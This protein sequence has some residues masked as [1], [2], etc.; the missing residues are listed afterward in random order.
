M[1]YGYIRVPL[2][3]S[4]NSFDEQKNALM[5][6]GAKKIFKEYN[7][8]FSHRPIFENLLQS[9]YSG[10]EIIVTSLSNFARSYEEL[11]SQILFLSDKNITINILDIGRLDNSL[12]GKCM[13]SMVLDFVNVCEEMAKT[14][15]IEGKSE[16]KKKSGYRE[17]RPEKNSKEQYQK[18]VE[19]LNTKSYS[20]VE[21]LTGI[22]R[23]TLVRKKR[24]Y[25]KQDDG[26]E[27]K[28]SKS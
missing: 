5:E 9:L 19:M 17:G 3:D 18:A 13:T 23:S 27:R 16:A 20:E 25:L 8:N 22:S 15:M 2:Y 14:V 11:T 28:N 26:I 10:D 1:Q 12:L 4:K 7:G 21:K 24:E 6:A